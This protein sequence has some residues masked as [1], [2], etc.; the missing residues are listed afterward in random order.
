MSVDRRTFTAGLSATAAAA[1]A[2]CGAPT[3]PVNAGKIR[4]GYTNTVSFLGAFIAKDEGAFERHG[5]QVDLT[6]VA[7]NST[8]PSALVGGSLEI[9]G[10]TPPVL[11]AAIEGG[12]D[13]VII[14]GA[15][16]ND[17]T[18]KG[19]GVLARTGLDIKT[20]PDFV[21]KRVGVPGLGAY[22][23]VMFRRWLKD[24]GVDDSK[25]NFVEVPLAQASDVLRA[26]NVDAVL[27][28]EPFFS[29]VIGAK[30]GYL[31]SPFFTEMRDG[32]YQMY[33]GANRSWAETHRKEI[34]AFRAALAE[35]TI[36]LA[37]NPDESRAIL[38]RATHLPPEITATSV[39]PTLSLDVTP[40][41]VNY[42]ADTLIDQHAIKA[43]PDAA[44]LI[45]K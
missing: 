11:L 16:V 25:V 12:L 19:A 10:V 36:F 33:Y 27:V 6:L 34:A 35:A 41:D 38:G 4:L 26:G 13:I 5:L 37:A 22:M 24:K 2:S 15:A 14:A 17:I 28:G 39:L 3:Q 21:G 43:R 42:W 18:K 30:T 45:F 23:H 29:R 32:L 31:V 8:I 1:L 40:E 7:L 20:A 9:G 44:R